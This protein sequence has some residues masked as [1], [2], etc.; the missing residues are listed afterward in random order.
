MC[1]VVTEAVNT[2]SRP[3]QGQGK[4]LFV[5]PAV[6]PFGFPLRFGHSME[7]L[8]LHLAV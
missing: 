2:P 6:R 4:P 3:D 7:A 8:R 1:P 5:F